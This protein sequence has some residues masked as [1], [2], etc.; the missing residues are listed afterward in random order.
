M[1]TPKEIQQQCSNWW[2]NVLKA[3]IE[4]VDYFPKDIN[5]IGKITAKDLMEKL[6]EYR[7]SLELLRGSSKSCNKF[8]YYLMEVERQFE[9]IGKQLVPDKIVIETLE[10]YLKITGKEKGFHIFT[11]NCELLLGELPSLKE[12]A[13]LNPQKLIEYNTWSNIIKV[14]KFF[15]K[16]PKP[17]LYIRELPIDVHTKF[18]EEHKSILKELLNILIKEHIQDNEKDFEKRFNLK[19][20]EPSIRFR[21]LD[22]QI[23]NKYF[24]GT[25]D[26]TIPTSQFKNLNLPILERVFIVENK[27]NVLTFPKILGSIVIFGSGDGVENLK[28]MNW[29]NKVELFY[30]GDLDVQGFEILSRFRIRF[31]QV[32]SFLMDETTFKQ[33]ENAKVDGKL[34]NS[35][36]NLNLTEEEQKLYLLL[37][38]NNWRLEQE[39]IPLEYVKKYIEKCLFNSYA[40]P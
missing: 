15:I 9:K 5:R 26:L 39:K 8:G 32:Q 10:D 37:K 29:F 23:S 2:K 6:P 4:S 18:I 27:M 33:F 1:I 40:F 30:W 36:E 16:I 11:K 21:I 12:W 38:E 28:G 14:C 24:F 25:D 7:K 3:Y 22:E 35:A 19:Y 34:S 17:N 20:E 13:I 31:S